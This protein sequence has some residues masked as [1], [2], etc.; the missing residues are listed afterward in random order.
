MNGRPIAVL[1]INRDITRRKAAEEQLRYV[2][3]R[4]SLANR[5]A[6][7]GI[8]DL[9]WRTKQAVWDDTTFE[10]YGMNRVIPVAYADIARRFH[11][12]D[13]AA[14]DAALQRAADGEAQGPMEYRVIRPDGSIR[15]V[16]SVAARNGNGN[17]LR[18]VG[19]VVD[20]TKRKEM[21]EQIEASKVNMAPLHGC[22]R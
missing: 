14:I 13:R 9:D 2:T 16:S 7:I 20:I 12:E 3:E 21:E 4:L 19:T 5:T 22:L 17:A 10:I 15:H 8:W 6:S 18:L 11:P 1:E